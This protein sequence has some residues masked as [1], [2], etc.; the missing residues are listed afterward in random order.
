MAVDSKQNGQIKADDKKGGD[1]KVKRT[2]ALWVHFDRQTD[3]L[4]QRVVIEEEESFKD[5]ILRDILPYLKMV[6]AS[7]L[8][9]EGPEQNGNRRELENER[10]AL[11]RT[12]IEHHEFQV[13]GSEKGAE[14]VVI[15]EDVLTNSTS[16]VIDN[17]TNE[18]WLC[19]YSQKQNVGES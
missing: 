18:M 10:D 2:V 7:S 5:M 9:I 12:I 3:W 8:S 16:T 11:F 19:V 6:K 14:G 4:C 13:M 17:F 1:M 15:H